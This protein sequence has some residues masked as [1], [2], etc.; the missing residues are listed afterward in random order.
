MTTFASAVGNGATS[1][2]LK[3]DTIGNLYWAITNQEFSATYTQTSYVYKITPAG[4]MTT[5]ASV[6]TTGGSGTSLVFDASGNLYWA[7]TNWFNGTTYNLTS[8]VYKITPAGS[9]TTFSS[10]ATI[11]AVR[12]SLISDS[13]GNMY[14]AVSNYYNAT[15][16]NLTSFVYKIGLNGSLTTFASNLSTGAQGCSLASDVFGNLYLTN[17][18][19]YNGTTYNLNSYI[20]RFNKLTAN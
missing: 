5:F 4:S 10:V 14:W 17:G 15:T 12:T 9:M 20:Y 18:S 19:Y 2:D 7:V 1:T 11:G 6:V 8:Y 16:Y 13:N 3:F